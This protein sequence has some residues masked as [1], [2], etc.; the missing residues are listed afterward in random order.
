M[1]DPGQRL[2]EQILVLRC[3]TGDEVAF[4]E[5]VERYGPRL[6]YYLQKS[7]GR[8]DG[9]EDAYQEVWLV[10][11]RRIR[12]LMDPAAF[13]TWLYRIAQNQ[14]RQELRRRHLPARPIEEA[15][16]VAEPGVDPAGFTPED[17]AR[18]HAALDGLPLEHRE[19]LMLR[20]LEGLT[21]EQIA[22]VSGCGVGTVKSRLHYAKRAL[23][24]VLEEAKIHE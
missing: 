2:Y 14:V 12:G 6:R 5:L 9:A 1:T 15:D 19:A 21:Y 22:A 4:A 17:G 16:E 24:R 8:M 10:A 7:F 23:R 20:F 11:F 3:Q 13:V 18:I